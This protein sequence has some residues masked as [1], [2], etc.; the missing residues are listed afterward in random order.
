MA[1]CVIICDSWAGAHGLFGWSGIWEEHDGNID[2]NKVCGRSVWMDLSEWAKA[3]KTVVPHVHVTK[4]WPL[5]RRILITKRMGW[6]ALWTVVSLLAQPP[7]SAIHGLMNE[8]A[9]VTYALVHTIPFTNLFSQQFQSD[10]NKISKSL[11]YHNLT[12]IYS[13]RFTNIKIIP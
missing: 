3:T 11:T 9:V 6:P 1:T 8:V 7:L 13:K 10:L 4:G 5:Q 12:G 2:D